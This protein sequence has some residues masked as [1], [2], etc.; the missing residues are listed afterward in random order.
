[1]L[2]VEYCPCEIGVARKSEA[3]RKARLAA[4]I[5]AWEATGVPPRFA[6]RTLD[7]HPDQA[8]AHAALEWANGPRTSNVL[9]TGVVGKGKTGLAASLVRHLVIAGVTGIRFV[10]VPA[11]LDAMRPGADEDPMR[12]LVGAHLLVLDDLGAERVTDWVRERLYVLVNGRYEATRATIVTTNLDVPTLA[13]TVDHRMVSRLT[14][15]V[16]EIVVTGGR[17]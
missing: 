17:R 15:N 16:T 7:G 13:A 12:D 10:S 1:M 11:M 3:E 14:E 4:L 5:A 6:G 8:A 9:V 2:P